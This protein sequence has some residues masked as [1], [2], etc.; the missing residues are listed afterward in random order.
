MCKEIFLLNQQEYK[1]MIAPIITKTF[2]LEV[3]L[4]HDKTKYGDIEL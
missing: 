4:D 3:D 1:K 2:H